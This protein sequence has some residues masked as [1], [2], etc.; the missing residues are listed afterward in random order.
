MSAS[1]SFSMAKQI[2]AN[3]VGEFDQKTKEVDELIGTFSMILKMEEGQ[4]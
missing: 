1:D 4:Q 3:T 2:Y